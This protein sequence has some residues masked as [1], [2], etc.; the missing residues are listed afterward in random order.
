MIALLKLHAYGHVRDIRRKVMNH[1]LN[2]SQD[3]TENHYAKYLGVYSLR[4]ISF[5]IFFFNQFVI[6]LGYFTCKL[7]KR[8]VEKYF[9]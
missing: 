1:N 9:L 5:T 8:D 3:F 6:A 2:V 7:F 4:I